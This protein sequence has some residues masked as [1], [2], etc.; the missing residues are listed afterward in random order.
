[1]E[2]AYA[3]DVHGEYGT[4]KLKYKFGLEVIKEGLGLSVRETGLGPSYDNVARWKQELNAWEQAV[5]DR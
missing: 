5:Q 2:K 1:M 4:A 3:A